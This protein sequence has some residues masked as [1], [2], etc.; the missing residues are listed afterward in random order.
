VN[1]PFNIDPIFQ[2]LNINIT[3]TSKKTTTKQFYLEFLPG[4]SKDKKNQ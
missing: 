2:V 4:L 1:Y 3:Y